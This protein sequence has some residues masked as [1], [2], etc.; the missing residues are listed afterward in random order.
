MRMTKLKGMGASKLS[1]RIY[2]AIDDNQQG[3]NK[4]RVD[5]QVRPKR[6]SPYARDEYY[7]FARVADQ[8]K[9][10]RSFLMDEDGDLW[11][12]PEFIKNRDDAE[13]FLNICAYCADVSEEEGK[14]LHKKELANFLGVATIDYVDHVTG[15]G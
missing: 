14:A 11:E 10:E 15:R 7:T 1:Q 5:D 2:E 9:V 13:Q 6:G 3:R 8:N 4:E 12:L